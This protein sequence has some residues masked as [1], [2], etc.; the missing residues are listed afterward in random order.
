VESE[1][2]DSL[3]FTPVE[4]TPKP[5]GPRAECRKRIR[6]QIDAIDA[7][8]A[9]D[10]SPDKAKDYKQRLLALTRELREC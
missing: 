9:R 2:P 8:I 3:G 7:E 6:D 5:A 10:F 1:Q 4:K